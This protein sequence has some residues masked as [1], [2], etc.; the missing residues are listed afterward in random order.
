MSGVGEGSRVPFTVHADL[1]LGKFA[2]PWLRERGTDVRIRRGAAAGADRG[3]V[4]A[5]HD[6]G[7]LRR[8]VWLASYPKSGNTWVRI[9]LANF[10]ADSEA[11]VSING[12][13]QHLPS[14]GASGREEFELEIGVSSAECTDAEADM[15]MPALHRCRA[16]RAAK[17]GRTVFCKI[18]DACRKTS[19]GDPLIPEEVT[20]GALYVLRNPL[21]VA[22]SN[23][24][25]LNL[26]C[27][28]TV[29]ILNSPKTKQAGGSES[30]LLQILFDWSRHVRSWTGAP[31]P[32][33]AVRYEDLLAD[34]PGQLGRMARFLRLEGADDEGRLRR[35]AAFSS[36][37]RLREAED[38]EGFNESWRG[39]K[40]PFFRRGESGAWRRHLSA[41][42]VRS[43]LDAH[44]ETMAAFGY[45]LS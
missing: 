27:A 9:L 21:D 25:Y 5:I 6:R 7:G 30:Q 3:E 22:V 13:R 1:D 18:H 37:D 29:E 14:I 11:P 28:R 33:L 10:L 8:L 42:Q 40:H 35:T 41:E 45:D 31:F 34:T 4:N 36:F 15:L 2:E 19:A 24:F 20:L 44:A 43:V 23:A 39:L 16:V 38:R 12:T 32:V 26:D 17:A